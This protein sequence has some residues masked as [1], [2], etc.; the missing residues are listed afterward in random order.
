MIQIAISAGIAMLVSLVTMLTKLQKGEKF[1]I[2][3]LIRTIVIGLV[4]GGMAAYSGI[5]ITSEN[6]EA[7]LTANAGI[8]AVL[9]QIVK[10]IS[11]PIFEKN[12]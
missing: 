8:V 2:D 4:L 12:E 7:Y 6:W 11:R 5:E 9:D 10:L 3:K 1:S